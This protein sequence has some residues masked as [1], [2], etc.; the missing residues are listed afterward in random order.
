MDFMN[1]RE[2]AAYRLKLAQGYLSRAENDAVGRQWDGC[3][4]NAQE[5][6]ENAGKAIISHFRPT[7][8]THDVIEAIQQLAS[9]NTTSETVKQKLMTSLDSF[10]NMG[11]ETHIRATYGD[12]E[13]YTPPWEL[14]DE[15]ESKVGLEKARRAVALAE[16]IYDEMTGPSTSKPDIPDTTGE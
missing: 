8:H 16:E 7:S 6:V 12:E 3:L 9:L 13:H 5:A 14:I 1:S 11:L 15:S 4:A 10:Q 2:A